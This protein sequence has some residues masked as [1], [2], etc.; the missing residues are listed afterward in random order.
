MQ[1]VRGFKGFRYNPEVIKDFGEVI[2]PPYDIISPEFREYLAGLNEYNF[3]HIDLPKE[4]RNGVSKYEN[5]GKIYSKWKREG[6]LIRDSSPKAYW[7]YQ[8]FKDFSGVE[9][10][11]LALLALVKLPVYE[12]DEPKIFPHEKTFDKPIED[13]SLLFRATN[14]ELSPVFLLFSDTYNRVRDIFDTEIL[15]YSKRNEV[16]EFTTFDGVINRYFVSDWRDELTELFEEK[17]FYIADG[18]HRFRMALGNLRKKV[19]LDGE[20][21]IGIDNPYLYVFSALV[22]LEDPGLVIYSPHRVVKNLPSGM[23]VRNFMEVVKEFFEVESCKGVSL[24]SLLERLMSE[25]GVSTHCYGLLTREGDV[26]LIRLKEEIFKSLS[27]DE[28]PKV[29]PRVCV[30][31]L[32]RFIFDIIEERYGVKVELEYEPDVSKCVEYLRNSKAELVFLLGKISP[33]IVKECAEAGEFMPQ[34]STYFF[35][36]IPSGLVIYELTEESL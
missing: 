25:G 15:P 26:Y 1:I 31:P 6:V 11:R 13:R 27:K 35:P 29:V 5:A 30:Y 36:K 32:H 7:L 2:I 14:S 22:C 16:V 23:S 34:K 3:V 28:L 33:E 20:S 24:E 12:G 8:Q 17:V 19:E 9:Y 10:N 18:H 21:S 4:G